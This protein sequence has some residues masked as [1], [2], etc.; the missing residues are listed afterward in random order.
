MNLSSTITHHPLL[1]PSSPLLTH[2][3]FTSA[4]PLILPPPNLCALLPGSQPHY[5]FFF[6]T[7][8]LPLPS[9]TFAVRSLSHSL[10]IPPPP[11]PSV[12]GDPLVQSQL[13][14]LAAPKLSG[15]RPVAA[16]NPVLRGNY[17][18]HGLQEHTK[19]YARA[20]R[21]HTH[22]ETPH[23]VHL[24]AIRSISIFRRACMLVRAHVCLLEMS[25]PVS[26]TRLPLC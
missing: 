12:S 3:F 18:P 20:S 13:A 21:V 11:P 4:R 6:F 7:L 17:P 14:G 9:S 1:P 22:K 19:T 16:R 10:S 2:P 25:R 24:T 26:S 8:S 23:N 15:R 5:L